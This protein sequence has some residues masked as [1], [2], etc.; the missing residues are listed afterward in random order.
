[1][2]IVTTVAALFISS[3]VALQLAYGPPDRYMDPALKPY[4][5]RFMADARYLGLEPGNDVLRVEI[6]KMDEPDWVGVCIT[7]VRWVGF[8]PQIIRTIKIGG[9]YDNDVLMTAIM[10][11]ELGHCVYGLDHTNNPDDLM[12]PEIDWG[13][14]K[15]KLLVQMI[16]MFWTISQN[17]RNSK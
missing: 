4:Y 5:D 17:Q 6:D 1:M 12:Y 3:I 14:S 13:I 11:H 8:T 16:G 15:D 10:Y 2:T 7:S 9:M